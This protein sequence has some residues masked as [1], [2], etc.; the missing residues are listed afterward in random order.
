PSLTFLGLIA[1][2]DILKSD[3]DKITIEINQKL[4]Q[5][6]NLNYVDYSQSADRMVMDETLRSILDGL[7][8]NTPDKDRR[9]AIQQ[10]CTKVESDLLL[11]GFVPK[12]RLQ[13]TVQF[14]LLSNW[15][16]MA[17][18]RTVQVFD[19]VEWSRFMAELDYEEPLFQ[20]RLGVYLVDTLI[21]EGPVVAQLL[22][23]ADGQAAAFNQ[24]D[25]ITAID[26]RAV[27]NS[28]E[29]Q[30]LMKDIQKKDQVNVAILRAGAPQDVSLKLLNSP[31]EIQFNNPSLLF[32]RQLIA[33]K[34]AYSLSTNPLE[35]NIAVLNVGLCHMHFAEY[36]LAFEQLRQVQLDRQVGIGPGT[37]Q[38]RIAQCYRE[39][40]YK[41]ESG[42]SLQEASRFAQNTIY[43]DDG[44]SLTR[45]IKRAQLALQ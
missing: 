44:P 18:I 42:E 2:P 38:Y 11:I 15:S 27:K 9:T 43:S 41:K 26:G 28:A 17:D 25:Q 37:V 29:V 39:L 40:G 22:L 23:T 6:Q 8:T 24:G 30:R 45:E 33:F 36:D 1:A 14:Y 35:K 10:I 5:L 31:M 34:K 19:T 7:K 20:K 12:E 3:L 21:T 13:R 32:N 16:S 4:S